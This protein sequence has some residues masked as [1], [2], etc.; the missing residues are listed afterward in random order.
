[1]GSTSRVVLVDEHGG[2]AG[3]VQTA[4]AF[5]PDV[6]PAS[7]VVALA[8]LHDE[9]L[10]PAD[11]IDLIMSRFD[12]IETDDLAVVDADGHPIGILTEKYVRRRYAN[13]ADRALRE[14]YGEG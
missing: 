6:D 8:T 4:A 9:V 11:T 10:R 13:E 5:D 7:P 14:V 1:L 12:Q 2:Y 3:I